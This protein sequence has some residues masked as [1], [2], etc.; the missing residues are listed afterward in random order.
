MSAHFARRACDWRA[1]L[2]DHLAP[3]SILLDVGCGSADLSVIAA[4]LGATLTCVDGSPA[5]IEQARK[6]LAP[7]APTASL[8]V[9]NAA[10]LPLQTAQFDA[11]MASSLV[12]YLDPLIPTLI[13]IRRVVRP[14]GLF[15]CTV[16]NPGSLYRRL[17]G[18]ALRL[19][20]RPA[21]RRHVNPD[22][23]RGDFTSALRAAGFDVIET[24]HTGLPPRFGNGRLATIAER[25][26]LLATMTLFVSRAI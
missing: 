9:A 15:L 11:V 18:V 6:T 13:E 10:S 12:E 24:R 21:Y 2:H 17:E 26:P 22:I 16:P 19:T 4:R 8:L 23:Y 1:A 14:G 7:I 20:G 5:M 25:H 3:G